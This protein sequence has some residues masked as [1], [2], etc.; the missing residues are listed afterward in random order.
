MVFSGPN[1]LDFNRKNEE[2]KEKT[3]PKNTLMIRNYAK[4][5][6]STN[7]IKTHVIKH[8]PETKKLPTVSLFR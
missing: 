6:N 8:P 1:S 5:N 3:H 2:T 4:Q 7:N